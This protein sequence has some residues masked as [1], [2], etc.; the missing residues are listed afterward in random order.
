MYKKV[1]LFFK[2]YLFNYFR[3]YHSCGVVV[4]ADD[5]AFIV[6]GG[7]TENEM[8]TYL[9]V[10]KF[11][12]KSMSYSKAANLPTPVAGGTSVPLR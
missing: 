7:L 4:S 6:A 8:G 2:L 10:E 11:S 1:I 12:F 9:S 3:M 5:T